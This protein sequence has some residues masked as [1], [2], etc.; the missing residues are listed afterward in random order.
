MADFDTE[1]RV[2]RGTAEVARDWVSASGLNEAERDDLA[3]FVDNHDSLTFVQER[4][5]LLDAYAADARVILPPW[6]RAVRTTLAF[7]YPPQLV[8]VD[9][10]I[11][12]DSP[13]SEDVE[14]L[15]F[16]MFTGY[17]DPEQ[18]DLFADRAGVYTIGGCADLD[19][20]LYIG[21]TLSDPHDRRIFAWAEADLR[22]DYLDGRPPSESVSPIFESYPQFLAHIVD[23]RPRP[24]DRPDQ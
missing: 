4:D 13:Y 1:G 20:D 14:D 10:F 17:S 23:M 7:V 9:D 18:R 8:R 19:I 15:W 2:A 16:E 21:I 11:W 12:D 3:A 6:F 5:A 22:D 24:G